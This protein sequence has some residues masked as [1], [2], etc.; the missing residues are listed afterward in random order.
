MQ[1]GGLKSARLLWLPGEDPGRHESVA[2][3]VADGAISLLAVPEVC[4]AFQFPDPALTATCTPALYDHP[5]IRQPE[6]PFCRATVQIEPFAFIG[7]PFFLK[8]NVMGA[9]T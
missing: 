3:R 1:R 8:V 6:A 2:A 9:T 4:V 7:F 5:I